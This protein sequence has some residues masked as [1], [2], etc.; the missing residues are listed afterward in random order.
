M[1]CVALATL[2]FYSMVRGVRQALEI[3]HHQLLTILRF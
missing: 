2:L 3:F 1:L